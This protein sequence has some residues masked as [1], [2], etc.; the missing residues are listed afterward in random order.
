M[1]RHCT[2]CGRRLPNR[3][4]TPPV[5][6]NLTCRSRLATPPPQPVTAPVRWSPLPRAAARELSSD[7]IDFLGL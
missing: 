4:E 2:A 7:L 3:R 1:V 5:Y 6:C